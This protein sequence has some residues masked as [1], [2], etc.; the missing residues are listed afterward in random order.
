LQRVGFVTVGHR[1]PA[2]KLGEHGLDGR[3]QLLV[4][5]VNA[6]GVKL[7]GMKALKE[8]SHR[9]KVLGNGAGLDRATEEGAADAKVHGVLA[10]WSVRRRHG[11]LVPV[12][13]SVHF[14][15]ITNRK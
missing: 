6:P 14:I 15:S 4:G 1:F 10:S 12:R 13:S 9:L 5:V 11:S 7:V 3:G 2:F 8:V